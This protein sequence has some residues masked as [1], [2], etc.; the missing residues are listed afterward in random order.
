MFR[1]LY[2]SRY[3][4]QISV[5]KTIFGNSTQSSFVETSSI[6]LNNRGIATS[7]IEVGAMSNKS[8]SKPFEY[9][10]S[11][12]K[13]IVEPREIAKRASKTHHSVCNQPWK[14]SRS[15]LVVQLIIPKRLGIPKPPGIINL[16][17]PMS[18][19]PVIH[20]SNDS[21]P[22]N[23]PE[24]NYKDDVDVQ[25]W[26]AA[27]QGEIDVKKSYKAIRQFQETWPARLP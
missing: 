14:K 15:N 10:T 3:F 17:D 22:S 18:V 9:P 4:S 23:Y 20:L 27:Q 24:A 25:A 5:K 7:I 19:A 11:D 12:P 6:R 26:M 21:G 8:V 2:L 1:N 16:A 13:Y